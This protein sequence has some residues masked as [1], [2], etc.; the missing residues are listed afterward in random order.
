MTDVPLLD[1]AT[2]MLVRDGAPGLEVFMLRRNLNSDF[3]GGAY[4]F[5]GGAVDEADRSADLGAWCDGR[6]DAEASD[7]LGLDA[8]GLAFWVAAV[9]EA[10]EEAGVLL[11]RDRSGATV[12]LAPDEATAR[13][14]ADHRRAVDRG[15]RS[16]VEVCRDEDL[17]LDLSGM[18]LFSHWITPVG[19]PRRYDTR[20][21][22]AAAPEG[23]TPVHDDRE[24]VA[25]C[26]VHPADALDEHRAGRFEMIF[27]T[28]R[29]LE[30]L[31]GYATAA[32]VLAAAAARGPVPA[33]LPRIV[34]DGE[35]VRVLV[36]GD[37][38]YDDAEAAG[39]VGPVPMDRLRSPSAEPGPSARGGSR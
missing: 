12:R 13:R 30:A 33:V 5:P 11:A 27:P 28:I 29:T 8:G 4:V 35:R 25:N 37:E 32:E 39:P 16:L 6:S 34:I 7:C 3:V 20:F 36:P 26:W 15:E 38:G 10:F 21:F 18:H 31:A 17:V 2:V 24:T 19:A 1:A 9:R 23:Q 22:V 14:F